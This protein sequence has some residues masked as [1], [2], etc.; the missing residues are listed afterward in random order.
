MPKE[1]LAGTGSS[2]REARCVE[3]SDG[4]GTMHAEYANRP[5]V[6]EGA[7]QNFHRFVACA[8][9]EDAGGV[10]PDLVKLVHVSDVRQRRAARR[11]RP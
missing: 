7:S 2:S 8:E 10:R 6:R 1:R 9:L 5:P 3:S 11:Q 4:L